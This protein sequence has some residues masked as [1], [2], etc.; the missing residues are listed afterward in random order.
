MAMF[1]QCGQLV[2]NQKWF[3]SQVMNHTQVD[4]DRMVT[5]GNIGGVMVRSLACIARVMGLIHTLGILFTIFIT[6][7][8][9]GSMI[10]ILCTF[11]DMRCLTLSVRVSILPESMNCKH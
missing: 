3:E 9:L 5:S 6:S 11:C 7:F 10:M 2:H 8:R 4:A 1:M